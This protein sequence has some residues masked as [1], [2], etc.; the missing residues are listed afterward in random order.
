LQ[1]KERIEKKKRKNLSKN[2]KEE[3]EKNGYTFN[4]KL[5][6]EMPKFESM[7]INGTK[8]YLDRIKNSREMQKQKE[9]K[10]NPN[11]DQLYKKYYDKKGKTVL[12]KNKKLT[13]KTYQNYLNAFHNALMNDDDE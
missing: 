9:E 8:K 13:K 11:Y 3:L 7:K 5:N 6:L 12:D 1:W 2:Q 10:L 4:P